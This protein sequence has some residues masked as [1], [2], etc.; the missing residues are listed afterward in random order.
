KLEEA[1]SDYDEAISRDPGLVQ[2]YY[3]RGNAKS[4]LGMKQEAISDYDEAARLNPN[5]AKAYNNRAVAFSSL[6]K[7]QEAIKDYSQTL[8][9]DPKYTISYHNRGKANYDLGQEEEAIKDYETF[10]KKANKSQAHIVNADKEFLDEYRAAKEAHPEKPLPKAPDSISSELDDTISANPVTETRSEAILFL[11][12]RG[13]TE[14]I[15]TYGGYHFFAMFNYLE[16]IYNKHA[17]QNGAVYKKGLGD[18]FMAVFE[19]NPGAVKT[20][21]HVMQDLNKYNETAEEKSKINVRIGIDFGETKV[22]PDNDRYGIPVNVASRIEGIKPE[23]FRSLTAREEEF[24][25]DNRLLISYIVYNSVKNDPDI[26]CKEF[27]WAEFKGLEGVTYNLFLIDWTN[28][29]HPSNQD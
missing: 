16:S 9:I 23:A 11:D 6:G 28:C 3:N 1:I 5:F 29:K 8:R 12:I 19:N 10:I 4:D 17:H 14:I 21:I 13:S 2:A 20:A 25:F 18:G 15:N 7:K 22:A 26:V 27:G 24:P